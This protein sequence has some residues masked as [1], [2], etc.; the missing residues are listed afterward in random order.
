MSINSAEMLIS[1]IAA[2]A[3]N[4]PGIISE[5]KASE[6]FGD[7]LLKA[8]NEI[9]GAEKS[10]RAKAKAFDMEVSNVSL[11]EVMVDLQKSSLSLQFGT[12]VRNKV[13]AAYQ[14]IMNMSI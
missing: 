14:E 8:I 1:S 2:S 13:V 3:M 12:Q 7:V 10:A 9:S 5:N 11:N 4:K 6:R